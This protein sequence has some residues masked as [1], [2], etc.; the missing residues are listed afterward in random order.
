M[1]GNQMKAKT[2][3]YHFR[4]FFNFLILKINKPEVAKLY[5]V[6]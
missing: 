3:T 2:Q 6:M 1:L 4:I 5:L